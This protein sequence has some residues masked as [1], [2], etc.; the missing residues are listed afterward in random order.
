MKLAAGI[1]CTLN[2]DE[3]WLLLAEINSQGGITCS[4]LANLAI[5]FVGTSDFISECFCS[6]NIVFFLLFLQ[7][8]TEEVQYSHTLFPW[9]QRVSEHSRECYKL[10]K[11]D[12]EKRRQTIVNHEDQYQQVC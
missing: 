1:G 8:K 6:L 12:E 3:K 2:S 10:A 9:L 7:L 11:R 4:H 5:H